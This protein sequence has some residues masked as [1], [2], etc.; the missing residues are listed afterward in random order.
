MKWQFLCAADLTPIE[1]GQEGVVT[2]ST[3]DREN[4]A[5]VHVHNNPECRKAAR[6]VPQSTYLAAKGRF[7]SEGNRI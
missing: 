2:V 4:P 5:S 1:E 7:D 3:G 6:N